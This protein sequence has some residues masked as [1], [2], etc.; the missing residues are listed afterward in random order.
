MSDDV[1][2]RTDA[3]FNTRWDELRPVSYQ[4]PVPPIGPESVLIGVRDCSPPGLQAVIHYS[5][6]MIKQYPYNKVVPRPHHT[7]IR[8]GIN[9]L[10]QWILWHHYHQWQT[11]SVYLQTWWYS[12]LT[13]TSIAMPTANQWDRSFQNLCF[14]W[15][16]LAFLLVRTTFSLWLF[17]ILHFFVTVLFWIVVVIVLLYV[18]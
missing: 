15:Y 2:C 12:I 3:F 17:I 8:K 13:V 10:H 18:S 11:R 6:F 16:Y 1:I 14:F 7:L 5:A 4:C 9:G